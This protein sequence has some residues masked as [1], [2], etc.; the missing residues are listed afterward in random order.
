MACL[1][2]AP[3]P[4]RAEPPLS[5]PTTVSTPNLTKLLRLV[6]M[7]LVLRFRLLLLVLF[8]VLLLVLA[9][10]AKLNLCPSLP[11]F[12]SLCPHTFGPMYPIPTTSARRRPEAACNSNMHAAATC[13]PPL[14]ATTCLLY[15][16]GSGQLFPFFPFGTT[17]P[18]AVAAMKAKVLF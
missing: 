11:S 4:R 16:M 8:L 15:S 2:A 3:S 5:H 9:S 18:P 12:S 10:P 13:F 14:L 1:A 6:M 17:Y 7:L